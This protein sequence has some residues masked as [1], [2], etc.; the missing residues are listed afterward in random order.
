MLLHK[1]ITLGVVSVHLRVQA[2]GSPEY[3]I[4][5]IGPDSYESDRQVSVSV[6]SEVTNESAASLKKKKKKGREEHVFRET[7][8]KIKEN[9]RLSFIFYVSRWGARL[10]GILHAVKTVLWLSPMRSWV[11]TSA[12]TMTTFTW[13]LL[14]IC[15][16]ALSSPATGPVKRSSS[17]GDL[18]CANPSQAWD[19]VPC[20]TSPTVPWAQ[21]H[22]SLPGLP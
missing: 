2:C 13:R 4:P 18:H 16:M 12:H 22:C 20:S 17:S 6:T 7:I 21:A 8:L 5:V 11:T 19:N 3:P 9:G 1:G 14:C 15:D 10:L